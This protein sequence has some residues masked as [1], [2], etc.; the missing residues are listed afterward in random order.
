MKKL[1]LTCGVLAIAVG[2]FAQGAVGGFGTPSPYVSA[3]VGNQQEFNSGNYS[4]GLTMQIFFSTAASAA[5]V[6]AI[7]AL[8]GTA[9]G[10]YTAESATLT[11]EGFTSVASVSGLTAASDV[12][13]VAGFGTVNLSSAFAPSTIGYYALVFTGTSG[14]AT[15]WTSVIASGNGTSGGGNYGV[16]TPGTP[17]SI[18]AGSTYASYVGSPNFNDIDLVGVVPE[19]TSMVLAGL[20]G[21]SLLALRRKK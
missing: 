13:S 18:G 4:G 14:A 9:A 19:P 15:G 2:A 12:S 16:Q 8:N 1:V 17:Y 5:D 6:A 3:G 7:N 10:T 20:G 11:A 21:L